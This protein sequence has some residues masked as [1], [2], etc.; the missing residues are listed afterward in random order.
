MANEYFSRTPSVSG[1]RTVWTFSTWIKRTKTGIYQGIFTSYVDTSNYSVLDFADDDCIRVLNN[2]SGSMG[3][4][5]K[6]TQKFRDTAAWYHIV[7]SS[8]GSSGIT[9]YI[10]GSAVSNYSTNNGSNNLNWLFN[11][12][13]EQRLGREQY[14]SQNDYFNGLMSD[15][16]MVDG[17]AL[18]ASVFG[19][20]N[21]TTGQWEPKSPA[22]IRSSVGS[23]GTNGFYLPFTNKTSTTTLGYDYKTADRSSNNDFTLNNGATTDAVIDGLTN[24]FCTMNALTVSNGALTEGGTRWA[25]TGNNATVWST[26]GVNTGKWYFEAKKNG[27]GDMALSF[28]PYTSRNGWQPDGTNLSGFGIYMYY[29]GGGSV[30]NRFQ[31]KDSSGTSQTVAMPAG[32]GDDDVNTYYSF[33]VDFSTRVLK[34]R[35]NNDVASEASFTIPADQ[36]IAPLYIGYSVSATWPSGDFSYNFG[37]GGAMVTSNSGAGYADSNGYGSFQYSPPSTYLAICEDN[38]IDPVLTPNQHF[39]VVTYTGNA[40]ARSITGVG[41]RP[42]FVWS[43]ARASSSGYY[44]TLVNSLTGT[45][46]ALFSNTSGG[47]SSSAQSSGGV[48]SFD[49]D[50]FSLAAGGGYN[51]ASGGTYVAYCWKATNSTTTTTDNN[52]A[53]TYYRANT[54]AGFSVIRYTGNGTSR[55]VRHGLGVTPDLLIIK[56]DQTS[57]W[58]VYCSSFASPTHLLLLNSVSSVDSGSLSGHG[59]LRGTRPDST[60]VYLPETAYN[61]HGAAWETNTNA[62]PYQ[63]YAWNSVPGFSRF[64]AYIG[65]GSGNVFVST[66]FKPAFV[67][68]KAYRTSTNPTTGW[69]IFDKARNGFNNDGA[70]SALYAERGQTDNEVTQNGVDFLSNGFNVNYVGQGDQNISGGGMTYIYAAFAE[71]PQEF[72]NGV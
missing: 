47:E 19:A 8:N 63:M 61:G 6:T 21:A 50:G 59:Y 35:R 53:T 71:I 69:R 3:I 12:T 51:N 49:S 67:M 34:V 25:P 66:G 39:N 58:R 32:F 62:I 2:L 48:T 72:A 56:G 33:Y 20:T 4:E 44:P 7:L 70:H 68:I 26:M 27:S 57:D 22:A 9:L 36:C 17:Q 45:G 24:N 14:I 64:G 46:L 11:H 16:F 15:T 43:I 30:A 40:T 54:T 41:F 13:N 23:F 1:N 38:N 18:A 65:T 10:N 37:Q 60:Y 29:T 42:D 31:Y 28:S 5:R 52:G 55:G